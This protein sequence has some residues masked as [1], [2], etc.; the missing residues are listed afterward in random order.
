MKWNWK[1]LVTSNSLCQCQQKSPSL[2][3]LPFWVSG[4]SSLSGWRA[5][6]DQSAWK[7]MLAFPFAHKAFKGHCW[8]WRACLQILWFPWVSLPTEDT[9]DTAYS[10]LWHSGQRGYM[11][12]PPLC[13]F[14][15]SCLNSGSIWSLL[16]MLV[17]G[18]GRSLHMGRP[19]V[20]MSLRRWYVSWRAREESLVGVWGGKWRL[21]K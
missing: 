17:S 3:T 10:S 1:C 2:L 14:K 9:E 4:W 8:H 5:A 19:W 16:L 20:L 11:L 12:S 21:K 13:P 18:L 7:E 6:G 15:L